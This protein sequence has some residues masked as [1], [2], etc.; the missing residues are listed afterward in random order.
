MVLFLFVYCITSIAEKGFLVYQNL[1]K[2]HKK[3]PEK[4]AILCG[5]FTTLF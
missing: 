5:F 4:E 3:A 1:P 2:S